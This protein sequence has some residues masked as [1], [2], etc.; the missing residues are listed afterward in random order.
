QVNIPAETRFSLPDVCISGELDAIQFVNETNSVDPVVSWKWTT[1]NFA[2]STEENPE[3]LYT[4]SG[5][6]NVILESVTDQGCSDIFNTIISLGDKSLAEFFWQNECYG[7]DPI[8]FVADTDEGKIIS[9]RWNYGDGN[10]S[11]D[12]TQYEPSYFYSSTGSYDVSLI[13]ETGFGCVDTMKQTVDIRPYIHF[14]EIQDNNYNQDFESG[15]FGWVEESTLLS[16]DGSWE[17]GIPSGD[18]INTPASGVRSWYTNIDKGEI[19]QSWISSPCFDFSEL[20]KPMIIMNIWSAPEKGRN[21]VVLQSS[22]DEGTTWT[23]VGTLD[24]G[25]NWYNSFSINGAPGG[26]TQGWS[27]EPDT[28]WVEA[29]HSLDEL[30]GEENVRFRIAFGADGGALNDF[31]GFAFDDIWIGER[32]RIVLL[33]HFTNASDNASDIANGIINPIVNN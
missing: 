22:V 10:V 11:T 33:E 26:Q 23:N 31:D 15:T 9:F 24:D 27:D 2:F 5:L 21:G 20:K 14:Q 19:E 12:T 32:S 8:T 29:R 7:D 1:D 28:A 6:K 3:Y 25:I 30:V 18:I 17:L 4:S 16:N 13:V